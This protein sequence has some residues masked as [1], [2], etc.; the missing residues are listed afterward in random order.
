MA[1][2]WVLTVTAR[3]DGR[4]STADAPFSVREP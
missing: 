4:E 1:G 3:K 2:D